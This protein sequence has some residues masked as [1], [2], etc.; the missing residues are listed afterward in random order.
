MK[1]SLLATCLH[2]SFSPALPMTAP[3]LEAPRSLEV[4]TWRPVHCVLD[5]VFPASEAQVHLALGNQTLNPTVTRDG[6]TLKA[7]A[8]VHVDQEGTQ[9]IAC[10]VTLAGV[11]RYAQNLTTVFSFP[12]P[13]LSLSRTNIPKGSTVNV[14]CKAG[15]R[16]QVILDGV[17][18]PSPGEPAQLQ[19]IATDSDNGRHFICNATL[20]VAGE[21][22][23]RSTAAQLRVLG[24]D[25]SVTIGVTVLTV[26]GVVIISGAL[27]YVFGMQK[28]CG[29]YHVKQ[30]SN[31]VPLTAIQSEDT[32]GEE[33]SS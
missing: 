32:P 27:L 16:A 30:Q 21:L 24:R 18:A 20:V 5:G 6:D 28:R 33:A 13:I 9:K 7:T 26:L 22:I 11:S 1:L 4:G 3:Y 23:C 29:I 19:L 25:H 31:S 8:I 12:G 10:N 14:T 17:L 2:P 15:P